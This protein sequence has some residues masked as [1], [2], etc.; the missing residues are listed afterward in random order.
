MPR[1]LVHAPPPDAASKVKQVAALCI[2]IA[3]LGYAVTLLVAESTSPWRC[4]TGTASC[5][6]IDV[7]RWWSAGAAAS[8]RRVVLAGAPPADQ[9]SS[10]DSVSHTV[11]RHGRGEAASGSRVRA[12]S[13]AG[14]AVDLQN[15][16]ASPD[17]DDVASSPALESSRADAAQVT[18][19]GPVSSGVVEEDAAAGG[20]E[21]ISSSTDGGVRDGAAAQFAQSVSHGYDAASSPARDSSDPAHVTDGDDAGKALVED[22][23]VVGDVAMPSSSGSDSDVRDDAAHPGEVVDVDDADS[24]LRRELLQLTSEAPT[25]PQ[26]PQSLSSSTA[27]RGWFSFTDCWKDSVSTGGTR[28]PQPDTPVTVHIGL[29]VRSGFDEL[30]LAASFPRSGSTWLYQTLEEVCV[31][32]CVLGAAAVEMGGGGGRGEGVVRTLGEASL[33]LGLFAGCCCQVT[34]VRGG[35]LY[36]EGTANGFYG[37][38]VV[39]DV[40]VIQRVRELDGPGADQVCVRSCRLFSNG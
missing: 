26:S 15:P 19:N 38:T 2:F 7:A 29:P 39:E 37:S 16:S 1:L 27:Q 11:S 40:V 23:V 20:R 32:A 12:S 3:T 21:T 8:R 9:G 6:G 5:G 30:V 34:G 10:Y 28:C 35:S 14:G 33:Q 31:R 4:A 24:R 18:D 13:R 17:V 36:D 22:A 25:L